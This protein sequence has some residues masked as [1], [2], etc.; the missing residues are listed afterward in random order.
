MANQTNDDAPVKPWEVL[1]FE[2]RHVRRTPKERVESIDS[3]K[4]TVDRQTDVY[5]RPNGLTLG[6]AIA[7]SGSA[8]QSEHRYSIPPRTGLL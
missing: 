2:K 7:I 8:A 4:G 5:G 6:T 1:Q 3:I